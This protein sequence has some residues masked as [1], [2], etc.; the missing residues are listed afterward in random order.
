MSER[1]RV[2]LLG[3]GNMGSLHA[4]VLRLHVDKAELVAVADV[5]EAAA[6]ACAASLGAE[7]RSPEEL[8]A[9]ASVEAVVIATPPKTHCG[10]IA[11]AAKAGKHVFCEKPIGWDLGEIDE[12]LA[13]VEAA[14]TKLQIGFNRRFDANFARAREMIAAGEIGKVLTAFIIGR[15][16]A[17]QRPRG[18]DDGDLFFDTT[19]HDLDMA[20]F[21]LGADA[22]SVYVQAGVMADERLDDPDTALTTLRF[23]NGATVVIDNNRLSGHGYDQRVEVCGTKGMVTVGNEATDTV[24]LAAGSGVRASGPEPFFSERYLGSY[25]REMQSFVNCVVKGE[26]PAVTGADGRAAV[27]LALACS[28][29]YR[30]GQPMRLGG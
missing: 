17:E 22:E 13:A 4:R 1:V 21:L 5:D 16:P 15:D 8:L 7:A 10:L 11:D 18:R 24:S 30:E 23:G 2:G 28:R 20:R 19:I 27:E 12:A 25:V 14:G 29:S 6:R 9:D 26:E 3:A